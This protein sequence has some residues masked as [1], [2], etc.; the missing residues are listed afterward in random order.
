MKTCVG[1]G[2]GDVD[3]QLARKCFDWNEYMMVPTR[4]LVRSFLR[5]SFCTFS[6]LN[7]IRQLL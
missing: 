1:F 3:S 5:S 4:P 6:L 7:A 2:L